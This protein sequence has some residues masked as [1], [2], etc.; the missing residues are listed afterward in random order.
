MSSDKRRRY[1]ANL[2]IFFIAG[3]TAC[4][5]VGFVSPLDRPRAGDVM[6]LQP[7]SLAENNQS[8]QRT[9][10]FFKISDSGQNRKLQSIDIDYKDEPLGK[11]RILNVPLANM[12]SALQDRQCLNGQKNLEDFIQSNPDLLLVC[13]QV[14]ASAMASARLVNLNYDNGASYILT[15]VSAAR[16]IHGNLDI[17][18]YFLGQ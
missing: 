10:L 15:G 4:G 5:K 6:R 12:R 17:A 16:T 13:D 2:F 3:M 1:L 9:V 7:L 8:P 14:I 18:V 11:P